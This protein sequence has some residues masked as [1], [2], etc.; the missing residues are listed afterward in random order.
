MK[1]GTLI[2]RDNINLGDQIQSLAAEQFLP[3]ID[4]FFNRDTLALEEVS[5]PHLLIM[6]GWFS[7]SPE[8][9][10]PPATNIIP[11]F[12]GFHI[13]P[14]NHGYHHFLS[15]ASVEYLKKHEPVGC[16]DLATL[17]LLQNQGV[18]AFLSHCLT[19]TF[20]NRDAAPN[21][22]KVVLVDAD[23]IRI[24]EKLLKGAITLSHRLPS[25]DFSE[26][27]KREMAGSLIDLY[28]KQAQLVITTR[29]HCALPCLAM[30]IPVVFFGEEEED[31][32]FSG[33]KEIG[34]P[35]NPIS[36]LPGSVNWN[37]E[38]MDIGP[39]KEQITEI[40]KAL[41]KNTSC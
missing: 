22:G 25:P 14:C 2:Y 10:F 32:R 17:H 20:P 7:M 26:L 3:Q 38:V 8:Q 16:R 21:N 4:R 1:F 18:N 35:V 23:R 28:R 37:P 36:Y 6:Q 34:L 29:L 31:I 33:L 39:K 19:L 41:V 30:G 11:I 12:F 40:I 9:A 5:E 27:E 24:P 13:S 15:P